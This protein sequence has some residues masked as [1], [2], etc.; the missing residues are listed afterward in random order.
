MQSYTGSEDELYSSTFEEAFEEMNHSDPPSESESEF[1]FTPPTK[2]DTN[3][4]NSLPQQAVPSQS[5]PE[6]CTVEVSDRY[7]VIEGYLVFINKNGTKAVRS[8][9]PQSNTINKREGEVLEKLNIIDMNELYNRYSYSDLIPCSSSKLFDY[10]GTE[11]VSVIETE[12]GFQIASGRQK[13][14]ARPMQVIR[15]RPLHKKI[16]CLYY[17][18][19]QDTIQIATNIN[20]VPISTVREVGFYKEKLC[21]HN[22]RFNDNDLE[23]I[24]LFLKENS[25]MRDRISFV[26]MKFYTEVCAGVVKTN[27][28]RDRYGEICPFPREV[29]SAT[30]AGYVHN[31][32]VFL[33]LDEV[34]DKISCAEKAAR[35]KK[36]VSLFDGALGDEMLLQNALYWREIITNSSHT[37][38][39]ISLCRLATVNLNRVT[40][41]KVEFLSVS[42]YRHVLDAIKAWTT[43]SALYPQTVGES[44]DVSDLFTNKKSQA[45]KSLTTTYSLL[46]DQLKTENRNI[47]RELGPLNCIVGNKSFSRGYLVVALR[48]RT[49]REFERALQALNRFFSNILKVDIVAE[50][51]LRD[52]SIDVSE[53]VQAV[54]LSFLRLF[55]GNTLTSVLPCKK[56]AISDSEKKEVFRLVNVCARAIIWMIFIGTGL[57]YLFPEIVRLKFSGSDRNI[58]IDPTTRGLE[59]RTTSSMAQTNRRSTKL[60]DT[61]TSNYLFFYIMII[62]S[63]RNDVVGSEFAGMSR[64][65]YNEMGSKVPTPP[66]KGTDMVAVSLSDRDYS[67]QVI[68]TFL[69]ADVLAGKLLKYEQFNRRTG[70]YPRSVHKNACLN[71]RELRYGIM[72]FMRKHANMEKITLAVNAVEEYAGYIAVTGSRV[73]DRN[74]SAKSFIDS[75]IALAWH[76]FL[77]LEMTRE[78]TAA[79]KEESDKRK[80]RPQG[81]PGDLVV[82]GRLL[83]GETFLFRKGQ[84]DVANAVY[85]GTEHLIPVQ[86]PPGSGKT[87]LFQIP[88]I[89][90]KK[91]N[92]VPKV[93]SFVFVPY[94]PLKANM[95]DRLKTRGILDVGDV[96]ELWRNGDSIEERTLTADVYVGTFRDMGTDACKRLIGGWYQNFKKTF[97]GL[98]VVDEVQN[99]KSVLGFGSKLYKSICQI[100]FGLA[101]KVVVLSSTI[102][103]QGFAKPLQRIGFETPL[104]TELSL[105]SKCYVHNL[106]DEMPLASSVKWFAECASSKLCLER[107]VIL[108][109]QFMASEE[110]SKAILVCRTREQ[111]GILARDLVAHDSLYIHDQ[112]SDVDQGHAMRVFTEDPSKRVLIGTKDVTEGIDVQNLQ[113]VVLVDYLPSVEVF[114]Q[115]A[116]RIR[117]DGLCIVLWS[118]SSN[119]GAPGRL[120]PGCL[121]PQLNSFYVLSQKGHVGCC[122][123]YNTK[124]LRPVEFVERVF[125]KMVEFP[126]L[127]KNQWEAFDDERLPRTLSTRKSS[128]TSE[129]N[130]VTGS[131]SGYSFERSRTD[132]TTLFTVPPIATPAQIRMASKYPAVHLERLHQANR[133]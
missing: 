25:S 130:S 80:Y 47:V 44:E 27:Y 100:N 109:N 105:D 120:T 88:L 85:L 20:Y 23:L 9:I 50:Q 15:Y 68:H 78:V 5:G 97:L 125:P 28:T 61:T 26:F 124:N 73:Y 117:G 119:D 103:W 43:Y 122:G 98:I 133:Q 79:K 67:Y 107:A 4:C 51:L 22:L 102:G 86:A 82:A 74:D 132:P 59:I 76:R 121:T 42:Q 104:T 37:D 72:Y 18:S 55:V 48:R 35:P 63:L 69:F 87:V 32:T 92:S 57:P 13:S 89:A 38:Y 14:E 127:N 31:L 115:A 71:F 16:K 90:V 6:P 116:G 54:N 60:L 114:V 131:H 2:G 106:V 118:S 94:I 58:Y 7:T 83:Y 70:Q 29:A 129:S 101:W 65:L 52:R 123:D 17:V 110:K 24:G 99:F 53:D 10:M 126:I 1:D 11:T 45:W 77:G 64:D 19:P 96:I 46:Y 128:L 113:L 95:I 93:V 91:R 49:K 84:Q 108:V 111:V 75:E 81:S 12:S 62:V 34:S 30:L 39:L 8:Y 41:A 21:L 3:A 56:R 66:N 112:L 33:Y 40:A 36:T